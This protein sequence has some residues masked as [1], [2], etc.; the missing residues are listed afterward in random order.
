VNQK[1]FQSKLISKKTKIKLYYKA[2]IRLV[3]VNGFE[4]WVLTENI[5]QKLL[6]LERKIWRRIFG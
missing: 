1:I 6:V 4:Y 5:R 2:V 3:I